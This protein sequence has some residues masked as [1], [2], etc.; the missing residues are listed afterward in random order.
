MIEIKLQ[1]PDGLE[2]HVFPME[3]LI[4][5]IGAINENLQHQEVTVQARLEYDAELF[6]FLVEYENLNATVYDNDEI[7]FTGVINRDISWTDNGY[8]LPL[9]NIT[10]TIEDNTYLL[11]KEAEYEVYYIEKSLDYIIKS[12][13]DI[14]GVKIHD[15]LNI[16]S[17]I[18]EAFILDTG[19]VYLSAL[20]NLMFQ[21]G[22]TFTFNGRGEFI[23]VDVTLITEDR[24][25]ITDENFYSGLQIQK[26]NK[27]YSGIK[28]IYNELIKKEDE[29]VYW[30]GNG[31]NDVNQIIPITIVPNQYYPYESDPIVEAS[32]G[33]V[34][35]SFENGYAESYTLYNGETR[36]RR[37]NKTTLVYTENHRIVEDWN[38]NLSIDRTQFGAKQAS[39][40]FLNKSSNDVEL[41]QLA[42]R[43]DA[44]YRSDDVILN[45]GESK[46]P[47]EY[48]AEYIFNE[49]NA[50]FFAEFI[51]RFFVGSS[52]KISGTTSISLPIG[53]HVRID[54]G[55]S[56]FTCNAIVISCEYNY[57]EE[58]YKI[59]FLTYGK[60]S[61]ISSRYKKSAANYGNF[62]LSQAVKKASTTIRVL[63]SLSEDGFD[64]EAAVYQGNVY[65]Y[66]NNR[67]NSQK[68][69]TTPPSIPQMTSGSTDASGNITISFQH[70][71]DEESG[72]REYNVYRRIENGTFVLIATISDDGT[73]NTI[74]FKDI[75]A[76]KNR[77]YIYCVTAVDNKGNE[78]GYSSEISVE[79][80]VTVTPVLPVDISSV[81]NENEIIITW[82]SGNTS[83]AESAARNYIVSLSR[84]N[85]ETWNQIDVIEG[86]TEAHYKFNRTIDLYPEATT[87]QNYKIRI[88]SVSEWGVES[89][90]SDLVSVDTSAYKTWVI[91]APDLTA[92]AEE[93]GILI[94]WNLTNDS[95]GDKV[96]DLYEGDVI[97]LSDTRSTTFYYSL[98]NHEDTDVVEDKEFKI[99]A[100]S[101]ASTGNSLIINPDVTNYLG[102]T[103]SLPE[104]FNSATSRN[105]TLKWA[106]QNIYGWNGVDIQ[107]AKGYKI[108]NNEYVLIEDE[109]ELEWYAPALG[110]NPYSSY[111]NYKKGEIGGYLNVK[112]TSI[113]FSL[114]L[115]GQAD[116][117]SVKTMYVY[118]LRAKSITKQTQWTN[119]IY[120]EVSP[121]SA[122]D[123]VKSW[124]LNASGEK[125][126]VDGALGANQIFV[127][128]LSAICANIGYITDGALQGDQYNYWAIN[129]TPLEDGSILHKGAFRVGGSTQYIEVV[130]I[131]ENGEP[132]GEYDVNFVVNDVVI[133]SQG[134]RID[135]K[136]F[137]VYDTE[138]N[139]MFKTSPEGNSILVE[140]GEYLT[141]EPLY[142]ELPII[143][144]LNEYGDMSTYFT[145]ACLLL[146]VYFFEEN[147][148]SVLISPGENKR[149]INIFKNTE[150]VKRIDVSDVVYG[151]G[152]SFYPKLINGK[153]LFTAGND[154]YEYYPGNNTLEKTNKT[155]ITMLGEG[156]NYY[157]FINQ[158]KKIY[159]I[160]KIYD[161]ENDTV[162][163]TIGFDNSLTL[164]NST[165]TVLSYSIGNLVYVEDITNVYFLANTAYF[166]VLVK[167]DIS[168]NKHYY[169]PLPFK[170]KK[171]TIDGSEG[172]S[173][174]VKYCFHSLQIYNDKLLCYVNSPIFFKDSS[175][176]VTGN[177]C[178]CEVDINNLTWYESLDNVTIVD[179]ANINIYELEDNQYEFSE[180]KNVITSV[181]V[182]GLKKKEFVER[183]YNE[184]LINSFEFIDYTT[185]EQKYLFAT[186][187]GYVNF[188]SIF[189]FNS[190]TKGFTG[191]ISNYFFLTEYYYNNQK[192]L[193]FSMSGGRA[194]MSE[195]EPPK[196]AI[197][198]DTN[199]EK[200][201]RKRVY[202]AGIGFKS[203]LYDRAL[204]RYKYKLDSGAYLEFD[205]NGKLIATGPTGPQ[206]NKGEKGDKGDDGASLVD[207]EQTQTSTQSSGENVI[208]FTLA[209]GTKRKVSVY[210]GEQGDTTISITDAEL[211]DI[212]S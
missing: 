88:K 144:G 208:T 192:Y 1:N 105:V 170:I 212:F 111:D 149:I 52:F 162:S 32:E 128:E 6:K 160:T 48:Q 25:T 56:G 30:Q 126:K 181:P 110:L 164:F 200:I 146:Y 24:T 171:S 173:D 112:G 97:I 17:S 102:Y 51:S 85:G 9:D 122:Y 41:Y 86:I 75:I 2:K 10:I 49:K 108:V 207:V 123:V 22:Y 148:F 147:V 194:V 133:N 113:S 179:S 21:Y 37:S 184:I 203:I 13:C 68:G 43:A 81:A 79:S 140:E 190:N 35:Q 11:R 151:N 130:P 174:S 14:C 50:S 189:T 72:V 169:K 158:A 67:W 15:N 209:D 57:D 93:N 134:T 92:I 197:F 187:K 3:N 101:I 132:T 117:S 69:D 28:V 39:V 26:T 137:E 159:N 185:P 98:E 54:T 80:A 155:A 91:T 27:N 106:E 63:K 211:D 198:C 42:I 53:T 89:D 19:S 60:T 64:N 199:Y 131:L 165:L 23:P 142:Y 172:D 183:I 82:K 127:E 18:V 46:Q 29:Q 193:L 118:R 47:Y 33:Q 175:T 59:T 129:D 84:D 125:V 77:V 143:N 186:I 99:V 76:K 195:F 73:Q 90:W 161:I 45:Y 210:N 62:S 124:K 166:T 95:Y 107:V 205:S 139:L 74:T 87:L 109:S 83:I 121:V 20:E 36:Y 145:S 70:S 135:G 55:L 34:F 38:G 103:P 206:G 5:P 119:C 138:G 96:F 202:S 163:D 65:V 71:T 66:T 61:V 180:I 4:I 154:I 188:R 150:I 40:R 94:N 182:C 191:I 115:Y 44:Y 177:S 156:N 167:Y 176:T 153:I 201:T 12:I 58:K 141:S 114:P 7:I 16:R 116:E 136:S 157:L 204:G 168:L 178:I 152:F 31:L 196:Y 104:V 8:P 78:S 100:K 120:V